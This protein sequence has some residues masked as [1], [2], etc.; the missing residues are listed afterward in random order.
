MES[1]FFA[2]SGEWS[3]SSGDNEVPRVSAG[4]FASEGVPLDIFFPFS[5][6][7]QKN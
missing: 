5:N 1:I 7:T 3:E 2:P 4:E 6:K